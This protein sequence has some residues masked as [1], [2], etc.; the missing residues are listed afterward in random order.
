MQQDLMTQQVTDPS[1]IQSQAVF[2]RMSPSHGLP[3]QQAVHACYEDMQAVF[4][5]VPVK[6]S[7][8]PGDSISG[9]SN[10]DQT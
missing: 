7:C 6:S 10:P 4:P 5:Q 8:S 3:C 9:R 1:L 2:L